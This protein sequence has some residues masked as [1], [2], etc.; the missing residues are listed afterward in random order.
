MKICKQIDDSSWAIF[1]YYFSLKSIFWQKLT[2]RL[3]FE[4]NEHLM[5]KET[6]DAKK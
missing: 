6:N 5:N 3:N 4:T 1:Y 2:F